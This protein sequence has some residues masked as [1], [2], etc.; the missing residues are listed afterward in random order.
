MATVTL[1]GN[2]IN[3]IG[4]LPS[5]GSTL[6]AFNL[7]KNDLSTLSSADL[8][9]KKLVLNIFPSI[10]TGTCAASTRY[11]NQEAAGLDNTVVVCIS[12][13]LPFAQTRFCGAEGIENV[14]M[15]SD[16][17]D[18]QFGKDFGVLFTD[19]ALQGLLS[20]SVVVVDENGKVVYTE[21]VPE[22][23]N[24]PNYEAALSALSVEA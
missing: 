3:T 14:V 4:N 1:K 18:A 6:P 8:A 13:D 2:E 11:F 12:R 22:T 17:R 23:V 5:V 9:G 16:F 20:R 15:A 21:Q 10:D 24:E 19:G 7:V